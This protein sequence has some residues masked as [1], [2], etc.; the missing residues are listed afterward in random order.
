MTPLRDTLAA[1]GD[2]L[3]LPGK[4]LIDGRVQSGQGVL[5]RAGRFAGIDDAGA[6][7]ARHPRL[8]PVP[9][10]DHLL[11][12]GFIDTHAH[13]D[14]QVFWDP[15]LDPEPLHGV[16]TMLVGNCSLSLFPA[17]ERTRT[18]IADLFSYIED[19][20]RH[21]FD[22]A[23]P[24][25]WTDYAGYRD[26]VNAT[27]TGINLAPKLTV[28]DARI[29]WARPAIEIDRLIRACNTSPVAWTTYRGDRFKV[30]EPNH[31]L[32][33]QRRS[34]LPSQNEVLH[35]TRTGAPGNKRFEPLGS[36]RRLRTGFPD[37]LH[38]ELIDVVWN[39]DPT[40]QV[41]HLQNLRSVEQR[42]ERR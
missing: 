40:H 38:S 21:L 9:L 7:C 36:S 2:L 29:D 32:A 25:T 14:P 27:G 3:L 42:I 18:E 39:G 15:A 16:T 30:F 37:Q 33:M 10:P 1:G 26:T 6:L 8:D 35:R 11:M 5:V 12:P 34:R 22:D 13:T 17:T 23:V 24:W 28:A 4:V 19:V 41:L 20:P 31:V